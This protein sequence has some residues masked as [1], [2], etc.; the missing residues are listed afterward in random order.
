MS[1]QSQKS[2]KSY[3]SFKLHSLNFCTLISLWTTDFANWILLTGHTLSCTG[4]HD[5]LDQISPSSHRLKVGYRVNPVVTSP[6]VLTSALWLPHIY[7]FVN[8]PFSNH[9]ILIIMFP[10]TDCT[11]LFLKAW[12]V[13]LPSFTNLSIQCIFHLTF[14][15]HGSLKF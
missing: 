5:S 8:K 10:I 15:W 7:T 9:P 12:S 3:K 14:N 1:Q 11:T 4:F 2:Y 13:L 6:R